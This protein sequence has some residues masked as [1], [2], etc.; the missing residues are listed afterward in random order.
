MN[1]RGHTGGVGVLKAFGALLAFTTAA[2]MAANTITV[3]PGSAGGTCGAGNPNSAR[4]SGNCGAEVTF[5]GTSSS[6]FVQ[7]NSPASEGEYRVRFYVNLRGAVTAGDGYDGFVAA[8]GAEPVAADPIPANASRVRVFF[9]PAS[10]DEETLFVAARKS[11]NTEIISSG[12]LLKHGWHSIEVR[13]LRSGVGMTDGTVELWINGE[14]KTAEMAALAAFDNNISGSGIDYVRWGAVAGVDGGSGNVQMDDFVSQRTGYVG[15]TQA[16]TDVPFSHQFFKEIQG[17]YASGV[18]TGCTQ[19]PLSYCPTNP[20][21][22]GAMAVFLMRAKATYLDHNPN[23]T[24]PATTGIFFDPEFDPAL[25]AG[26]P[27]GCALLWMEPW[28]EALYQA[29]ITT[30]CAT[31]PLRYCPGNPTNRGA[32]AVF[33]L[34]TLEGPSY[35]PPA[36]TGTFTDPE[37]DS[38]ACAGTPSGCALVWMEPWAEELFDRGITSGCGGTLY[39]PGNATLRQAMAAFLSRG[40]SIPYHFVG[41]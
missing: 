25:C 29:G 11:D 15:P 2:A 40:L 10:F 4:F 12:I 39:C 16:F 27:S 32:M 19:S 8:S 26:T 18:T 34:R 37:F 13:W 1:M 24:P 21:N 33:I 35:T 41:P 38:V 5:D 30:G 14:K 22:R 6:A 7:D 3:P 17:F 28:A 9:V 20:V 31:N 36:A 23:Y